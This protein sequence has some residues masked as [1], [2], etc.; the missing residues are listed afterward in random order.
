MNILCYGDSNTRGY[1][2]NVEGYSKDAVAEY[3]PVD[4]C[5]WY[6]LA[7]GNK[8]T[9]NGLCGRCIN[10]ENKWLPNRN[11]SL[12]IEKTIQNQENIDIVILQLG[13]NDCKSS[14]NSSAEE[15]TNAMR[16]FITQIKKHTNAKIILL[17]P[18]RIMENNKITQKYYKGAQLKSEQLDMLYK[19]LADD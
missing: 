4:M 17:S 1:E 6:P 8:L 2:P 18:A 10:K 13:T 7:R 14:F 12:D 11:A 5:W 19:Y 15:I 3:Y 16:D 9:V